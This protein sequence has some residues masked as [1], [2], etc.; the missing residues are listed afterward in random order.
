MGEYLK[1]LELTEQEKKMVRK[2]E[3]ELIERYGVKGVWG[4]RRRYAAEIKLIQN[5]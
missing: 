5:F 3:L 1:L 2:T 4:A